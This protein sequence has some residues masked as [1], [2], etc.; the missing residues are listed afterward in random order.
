MP[1]VSRAPV[2]QKAFGVLFI[3]SFTRQ[4]GHQNVGAILFAIPALRP[5]ILARDRRIVALSCG[6]VGMTIGRIFR[7]LGFVQPQGPP[8]QLIRVARV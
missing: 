4:L 8:D 1:V 3:L 6:Q 2:I 7:Q 5:L